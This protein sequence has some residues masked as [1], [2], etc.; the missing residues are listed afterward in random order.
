LAGAVDHAGKASAIADELFRTEPDNTE[1]MWAG[2]LARFTLAELQIESG[3]LAAAGTAA[4]TACDAGSRLGGKDA[5]AAWASQLRTGCLVTRARLA[6]HGGSPDEAER[7]AKQALA[8]A[9][10][11]L[12]PLNR[13][14][15][16]SSALAIAGDAQQMLGRHAQARGSWATAITVLP[17]G[18]ELTPQQQAEVVVLRLRLGDRPGAR[19]MAQGLRSMGYRDRDYLKVIKQGGL[20]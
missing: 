8:S 16:S 18:L 6:L 4:R 12:K 17:K 9:K 20:S 19:Q 2:A 11:S 13:A 10:A 7:L 5:N 3:D 1:W 14:I 15:D